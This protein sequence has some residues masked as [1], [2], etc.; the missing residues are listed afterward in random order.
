MKKGYEFDSNTGKFYDP[1]GF[2][3]PKDEAIWNM[4]FPLPE[5]PVEG[6]IQVSQLDTTGPKFV[7][8]GVGLESNDNS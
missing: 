5:Q 8:F 4:A 6:E 1:D 3:V 7:P 2:E